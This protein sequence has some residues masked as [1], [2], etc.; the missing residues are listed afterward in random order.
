MLAGVT[1]REGIFTP[2]GECVAHGFVVHY[3]VLDCVNDNA[4][5]LEDADFLVDGSI[6][7]FGSHRIYVAVVADSYPT[8]VLNCD[9]PPRAGDSDLSR[10]IDDLCNRV[11]VLTATSLGGTSGYRTPIRTAVVTLRIPIPPMA[12]PTVATQELDAHRV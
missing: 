4:R 6:I 11:E 1:F 10:S 8:K 5:R 12:N 3:D 7:S 2:F 9:E